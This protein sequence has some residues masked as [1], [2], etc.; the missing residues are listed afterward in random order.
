MQLTVS[1]LLEENSSQP[2][3]TNN[4]ESS[5][6]QMHQLMNLFPNSINYVSKF[7]FNHNLLTEF[8]DIQYA[9]FRVPTIY[10]FCSITT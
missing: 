1:E 10:G 3:A 6:V 5:L 7:A 9:P 4:A 2:Q 8:K